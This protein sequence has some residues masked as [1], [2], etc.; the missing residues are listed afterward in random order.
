[1]V[2]LNDLIK[3]TGKVSSPNQNT[4]EPGEKQGCPSLCKAARAFSWAWESVTRRLE[5]AG[6]Y[7]DAL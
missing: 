7:S 2:G 4:G 1:M 3:V 6:G 5:Q